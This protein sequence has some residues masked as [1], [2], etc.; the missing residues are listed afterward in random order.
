MVRH[1]A[2]MIGET[3]HDVMVWKYAINMLAVY[4]KS[5]GQW[6]WAAAVAHARCAST[7]NYLLYGAALYQSGPCCSHSD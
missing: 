6:G 5:G 7:V 1:A 3:A 4:S 2:A